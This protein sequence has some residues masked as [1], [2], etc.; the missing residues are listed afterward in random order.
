[1]IE[2]PYG[3]QTLKFDP[4]KLPSAPRL[5]TGQE[6]PGVPHAAGAVQDALSKPIGS[7]RLHELVSPKDRVAIV[8]PDIT[9]T[10][11]CD[12]VLPQIL[13]E[14][15]EAGVSDSAVTLIFALGMHAPNSEAEKQQIVGL[16]VARRIRMVDHDARDRRQ[17]VV[18]GKTSFGNEIAVNRLV[19]E[20]DKVIVTG[21]IGYHLF[22]G[23]GGGRKAI[24]PGVAGAEV[25]D[26]RVAQL[27]LAS[28]EEH[29]V[30]LR[31]VPS[32]SEMFSPRVVSGRGLLPDDGR[33]IL[34]NSKI[35]ADEGFQVGDEI[36]LTIGGEKRVYR[37]GDSY[38]I[39]EG[40]PHSGV[41]K[42]GCL[43]MDY[44]SDPDRY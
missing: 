3:N 8:V 21:A 34:L 18:L 4:G 14:L 7:P 26:F 24:L 1:M 11:K 32:D 12:V 6:P 41:I 17:N 38:T 13:A 22:A 28:G 9:R 42:D 31:G 23:F 39:P 27:S 25:W 2:L 36:E 43:A 35:A 29:Q 44:F 30:Y 19:V 16:D 20:S 40:V 33:A 10:A 5:V 15:N 37:K